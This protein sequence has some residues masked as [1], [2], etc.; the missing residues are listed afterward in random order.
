MLKISA[1]PKSTCTEYSPWPHILNN[2]SLS[3]SLVVVYQ[4]LQMLLQEHKVHKPHA[5]IWK[6]K[7]SN[8]LIKQ[9]FFIYLCFFKR[10]ITNSGTSVCKSWPENVSRCK[11]V[12]KKGNI[13]LWLWLFLHLGWWITADNK[14]SISWNWLQWVAQTLQKEMDS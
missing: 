5:P 7:T 9:F 14:N 10:N 11:V 3:A 13:Y 8:W 12:L 6:W 4:C 1:K 2:S